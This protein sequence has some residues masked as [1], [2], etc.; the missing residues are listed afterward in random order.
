MKS[1]S[2]AITNTHLKINFFI[3]DL[4]FRIFLFELIIDKN[5]LWDELNI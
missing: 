3:S 5:S 2:N 1:S 4:F